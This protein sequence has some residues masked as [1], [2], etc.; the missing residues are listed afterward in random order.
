MKKLSEIAQSLKFGNWKEI[1]RI[2]VEENNIKYFSENEKLLFGKYRLQDIDHCISYH[3]LVKSKYVF[4]KKSEKT[5]IVHS[6]DIVKSVKR[7]G[8]HILINGVAKVSLQTVEA[9]YSCVECNETF[10]VSL[11]PVKWEQCFIGPVCKK[12]KK[13]IVCQTDSYWETYKRSM[14]KKFGC[15]FPLQ[16]PKIHEKFKN[17]MYK[18]YG[19]HYSGQCHELMIKSWKNT[20]WKFGVSKAEIN[21]AENI[22]MHF[23]NIAQIQS[24]L[25]VPRP[26]ISTPNGNYYPDILL[27]KCVI[28][29]Y[30]DYWHC[31]PGLYSRNHMLPSGI[32]A[33]QKWFKDKKRIDD[34]EEAGYR[35][36]IVWESDWKTDPVKTMECIRSFVHGL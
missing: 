7:S 4:E 31:N 15:D 16:S 23:G 26:K 24:C 25:Q 5:M 20:L 34:I 1:K 21:F 9:V 8:V 12:C 19:V 3:E 13:K 18:N 36:C 32:T 33:E 17:T 29:F 27:D 22:L 35:V 10:R 11:N 2:F 14:N 6:V 28:E 30:G